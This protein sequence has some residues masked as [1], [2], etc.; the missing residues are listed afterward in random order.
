VCIPYML[1]HWHFLVSPDR[2]I[3]VCLCTQ[4]KCYLP[5]IEQ[6]YVAEHGP[7]SLPSVDYDTHIA[8]IPTNLDLYCNPF[9]YM[10]ETQVH[11]FS[12]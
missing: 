12:V 3:C 2:A 6:F 8:L 7:P 4:H 1:N 5:T 9:I 10:I 11:F